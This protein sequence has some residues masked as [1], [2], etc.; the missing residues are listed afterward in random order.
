MTGNS[1]DVHTSLYPLPTG[2]EQEGLSSGIKAGIG[3][4]AV[5]VIGSALVLVYWKSES[6]DFYLSSL[7][8]FMSQRNLLNDYGAI[9]QLSLCHRA[10]N[11]MVADTQEM[12]PLRHSLLQCVLTTKC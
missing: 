7:L 6:C 4:L 1:V 2:G 3:V 8:S 9:K 12:S 5:A 10:C 11:G